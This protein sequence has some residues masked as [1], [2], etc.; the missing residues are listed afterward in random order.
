MLA[1]ARGQATQIRGKGEAEAAKYLTVF[2]QNPELA[3]FLIRL[4]ALEE[5]SKGN[6]TL[7]FDQHMPPFDLFGGISTNLTTH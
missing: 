1:A 5:S 3:S 6:S 2:Q 7:I 4:R